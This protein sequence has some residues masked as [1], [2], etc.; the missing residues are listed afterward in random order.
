MSMM[1]ETTPLPHPDL[2]GGLSTPRQVAEMYTP[3]TRPQLQARPTG[4]WEVAG[5]GVPVPRFS[6]GPGPPCGPH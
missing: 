2:L 6:W 3:R 1:S 5:E 4:R